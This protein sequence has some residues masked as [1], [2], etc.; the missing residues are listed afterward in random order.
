MHL[1]V[2]GVE[3]KVTRGSETRISLPTETEE[4]V[5]TRVQKGWSSVILNVKGHNE[6]KNSLKNPT[7]SPKVP[8]TPAPGIVQKEWTCAMCNVKAQSITTFMSHLQG[9]KHKA[10]EAA[11]AKS[12]PSPPKI[13]RAK[14]PNTPTQE[15]PGMS[16]KNQPAFSTAKAYRCSV[17][18]VNC[19]S[20]IDLES[21]LSGRKHSNQVN[22]LIGREQVP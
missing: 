18:K 17:C 3:P 11:K 7:V 6:T 1:Q 21:H 8:K 14:K 4:T 15:E 13:F 2:S 5:Q 20:K 10:N 16:V 12:Q 9:K 19:S 22:L